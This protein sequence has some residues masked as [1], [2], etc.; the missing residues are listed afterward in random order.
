MMQ[1]SWLLLHP[2]GPLRWPSAPCS[3][4][5]INPGA[6]DRASW[7]S[8]KRSVLNKGLNYRENPITSA[9]WLKKTVSA[10]P[11]GI[12]DDMFGKGFMS[13][14]S[15]KLTKSGCQITSCDMTMRDHTLP[16]KVIYSI[17]VLM[18]LAR[19]DCQTGCLQIEM[20]PLMH[21]CFDL[22]SLKSSRGPLPTMERTHYDSIPSLIFPPLLSLSMSFSCSVFRFVCRCP[23]FEAAVLLF[24]S[25]LDITWC[26][27]KNQ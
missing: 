8:S 6:S 25:S 20:R 2:S 18:S 12:F 24:N 1:C 3:V 19:F 27:C 16:M 26:N 11:P 22:L 21:E 10:W 7:T 15:F 23:S 9:E 13:T 4:T 5:A 17:Y 14:R